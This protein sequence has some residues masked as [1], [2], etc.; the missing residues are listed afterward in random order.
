MYVKLFIEKCERKTSLELEFL[1]LVFWV[2][3][4][5]LMDKKFD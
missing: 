1:S 2:G 5:S 4:E 3:Y